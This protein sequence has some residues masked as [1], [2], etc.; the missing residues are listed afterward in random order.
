MTDPYIDPKTGILRNKIGATSQESLSKAEY[1]AVA[2]RTLQLAT[3][4]IKGNF[5]LKYLQAIHKHQFQD[6]Y[7]WA[8]KVRTVDIAKG[9]SPFA[10]VA[11]IEPFMKDVHKHLEKDNYLRGLDK[12]TFIEKFTN[13]YGDINAAHPFREGN[14]RSTREFMAQLAKQAGYTL[15]QSVMQNNKEW[16]KAS[17]QSVHGRMEPLK[18]ILNDAIQPIHREQ[19]QQLGKDQAQMHTAATERVAANVEALK[20]RAG[21]QPELVL[22]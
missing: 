13:V 17:E 8:G 10:H 5:D 22:R 20:N 11:F 9:N 4:P 14:G 16:N 15:D 12:K 7:D 1:L 3:N 21:F 6:V 2:D 18:A 19:S